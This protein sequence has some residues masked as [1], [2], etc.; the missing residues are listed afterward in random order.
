MHQKQEREIFMQS[1]IE[2]QIEAYKALE[3]AIHELEEKISELKER[4][5]QIENHQIQPIQ[6]D[7]KE[8]NKDLR[9]LGGEIVADIRFGDLVEELS[10]ITGVLPDDMIA[11]INY[12]FVFFNGWNRDDFTRKKPLQELKIIIC[13]KGDNYEKRDNHQG[14]D[15]CYILSFIGNLNELQADGRR[16]VEHS[17]VKEVYD[18][19]RCS[20]QLTYLCTVPENVMDIICHFSLTDIASSYETEN[21][22]PKDLL[23]QAIINNQNKK[24]AKSLEKIRK[25]VI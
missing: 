2:E 13:K 5:Q 7:V 12:D 25:L 14:L 21:Y 20:R 1:Y 19:F 4:V 23:A 18:D 9:T 16:L 24:R 8:K 15:F 11:D 3:S 17:Y 10:E 22:Y 6:T